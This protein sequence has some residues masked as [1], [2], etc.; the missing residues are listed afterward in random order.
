MAMRRLRV[1]KRPVTTPPDPLIH[2]VL[3][4][5][6]PAGPT[7]HDV[8]ALA[9]RALR[10]RR[11]GH[12]GTLDPFATGLLLLCVGHATRIAEY[13]SGMD[14]RYSATVRLGVATDTDDHTGTVTAEAD[15][16]AVTAALV[17]QALARFRGAVLQTPPQYSAKKRDGERAYTAARQGR[18][19][20]FEPV[21]VHI[22]EL[23]LV[24]LEPPVVGL[25]V[26][27]S[28]GTYIRSIA[29]DLG[30]ALGVGG[31]LTALRRTA[32]GPH[33]VATALSL[34]RLAVPGAVEAALLPVI[35][36]LPHLPRID[37]DDDTAAAVGHGR[38]VR[39]ADAGLPA[40]EAGPD[41]TAAPHPVLMTAG[42]ALLGIAE[43]RAGVLHPRKVFT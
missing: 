14:K 34:D 10:T 20:S 42:G 32:I 6:K 29:R 7:S 12:T 8:V 38:R 41:S 36:A 40:P 13:L 5:D 3:P 31:H 30:S 11:I 16:S 2:G 17:E 33:S 26:L 35:A 9:R 23:T 25:E 22:H 21:P 43:L 37:L 27:C 4:V 24:S 1:T 28:S 18:V 15:T 39:L 19:V